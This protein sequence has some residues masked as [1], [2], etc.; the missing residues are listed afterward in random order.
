MTA[1]TSP[2]SVHLT[3]LASDTRT[4]LVVGASS[5]IGAALAQTL[6]DRG[7]RV[8]GTSR[9]ARVPDAIAPTGLTMLPVDVTDDESVARLHALLDAHAVAPD[10]VVLNAGA[11]VAGPIES[12]P[13]DA[14][15]HQLDLNVLGVH[16]MVRA[17]L[18]AMRTRSAGR[19]VIVGSLAGRLVLPFQG[20]YTAS[21]HAIA[22]YADA[23]R[24]EV[25]VHGI[26]VT[27]I[28]PGD[29]A[30]AFGAARQS[31]GLDD[32]AY[33]PQAAHALALMEESEA[34]GGDPQNVADAIVHAIEARRSPARQLVI[35]L[36]ERGVLLMQALLP[37]RIYEG[38]LMWNFGIPR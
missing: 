19:I 27:L 14:L 37:R 35:S 31:F 4:V 1:T 13:V 8:L 26:D 9:R 29:H 20:L 23:L 32:P 10:A 28:E 34:Q 12:T 11:G 15:R 21:K 36:M 38:L 3:P 22:A 2:D 17:L 18:P 25:A 5:G 24:M 30:T 16:R 6:S 7:F 33:A